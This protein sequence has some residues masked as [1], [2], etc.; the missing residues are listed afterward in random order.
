MLTDGSSEIGGANTEALTFATR[1]ITHFL[2]FAR[3]NRAT[4]ITAKSVQKTKTRLFL[5]ESAIMSY[6]VPFA[7]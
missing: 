4:T 6:V 7:K 3:P 1:G 2:I 5:I